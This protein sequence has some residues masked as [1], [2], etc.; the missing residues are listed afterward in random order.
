VN[1][2]THGAQAAYHKDHTSLVI[3]AYIYYWV[4]FSIFYV[5]LYISTSFYYAFESYDSVPFTIQK[6]QLADIWKLM[7]STLQERG[8]I[9]INKSEGIYLLYG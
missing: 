3:V 4:I 1:F 5:I 7:S 8:G 2:H 6:N 9:I